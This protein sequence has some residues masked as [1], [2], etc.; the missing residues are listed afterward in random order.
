MEIE[1]AAFRLVAQCLNQLRHS[2]SPHKWVPGIFPEGVKAVGPKGWE[3]YH[4]HVP[5]VLKSGSLKLLET[6]WPVQAWNG[7]ALH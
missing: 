7:I 1:P 2:V 3:T 6:S 4:I 5:S